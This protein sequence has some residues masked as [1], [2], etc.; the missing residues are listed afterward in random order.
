M[1][2]LAPVYWLMA[3]ARIIQGVSSTFVWTVGLALLCDTTPESRVGQQ[4]GLAMTGLSAGVVVAPPIGGALFQKLGFHAPF[5]FSIGIV[6]IDLL[7]RLLVIERKDAVPW[8]VDPAAEIREPDPELQIA[9]AQGSAA[10]KV[11]QTSLSPPAQR[12]DNISKRTSPVVLVDADGRLLVIDRKDANSVFMSASADEAHASGSGQSADAG[13][14]EGAEQSSTPRPA[15]ATKRKTPFVFIDVGGRLTVVDRKE[16][17]SWG[18][19]EESLKHCFLGPAEAHEP[20]SSQQSEIAA[21]SS[22]SSSR[23]SQLPPARSEDAAGGSLKPRLTSMQVLS[24]MC[25]SPRAL[26]AFSNTLIYG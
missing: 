21:S 7:G 22:P 12:K 18:A 14:V 15:K 6:L 1:F 20:D 4:L 24:A 11:E 17:I 2:M 23:N 19:R 25:L 5:I 10:E 16:L 26:A 13:A 3:L 8:G 9:A